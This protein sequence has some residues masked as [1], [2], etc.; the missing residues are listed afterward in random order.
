[1]EN[2]GKYQGIVCMKCSHLE[3]E[4]IRSNGLDRKDFIYVIDNPGGTERRMIRD[5]III[6][7]YDGHRVEDV[8]KGEEYLKTPKVSKNEMK[9][10]NE[11]EESKWHETH[12]RQTSFST[13]TYDETELK[14]ADID[15]TKYSKVVD[16]FFES[17]N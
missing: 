14:V 8:Y 7:Y 13:G 17:L 12:N 16:E 2:I 6:G 5:N 15:F 9:N 4:K 3:Y 10:R 11:N 1:M